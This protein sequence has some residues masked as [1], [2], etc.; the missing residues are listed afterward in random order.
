MKNKHTQLGYEINK[1]SVEI[2]SEVCG[3]I[4]VTVNGRTL[5][6]VELAW[7]WRITLA[8]KAC[9]EG[10]PGLDKLKEEQP[11]ETKTN[12]GSE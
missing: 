2:V 11:G 3:T 5:D 1:I 10:A 7:D 9:L 4:Q 6:E 8:A 12:S